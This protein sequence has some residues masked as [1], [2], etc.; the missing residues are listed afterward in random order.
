MHELHLLHN[1]YSNMRILI[2]DRSI[3]LRNKIYAYALTDKDL[4]LISKTRGYRRSVQ[5][6]VP[7]E[8]REARYGRRGRW[9]V[10]YAAFPSQWVSHLEKEQ[11]P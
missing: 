9:W 10:Q 4:F 5:I 11:A 7:S 2:P 1:E 6:G 8:S 3:E